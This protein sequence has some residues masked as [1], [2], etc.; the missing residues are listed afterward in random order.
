MLFRSVGLPLLNGYGLTEAPVIAVSRLESNRIGSVGPIVPGVEVKIADDEE[1]LT[2]GPHLMRGYWKKP[3]ATA[4]VIDSDGWLHTGDIGQLDRDGHLFIT[5]RKKNLIATAGGKKVA[6][7]PIEARLK[8]SPYVTQAVLIG[9]NLPYITALIV[10]N[11]ENLETYFTE[12]GLN[13]KDREAMANHQVTEALIAAAVKDA[14]GELAQYER[15][16]RFTI[17]PREFTM[18][19]GEVTPTLK[20][21]RRVVTDRFRQAI[22]QM[23]LKQHRTAG[24]GLDE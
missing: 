8:A 1:I 15:I 9:D 16:R 3:E 7:E 5:D 21:R 20:V 17:L 24:Y 2:R 18:D 14:N 22:D 6:P 4:E 10:P 23:Y 12:R 13:G 19:D 11:F